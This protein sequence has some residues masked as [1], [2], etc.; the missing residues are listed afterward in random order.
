MVIFGEDMP[1]GK[2]IPEKFLERSGHLCGGFA[3]S[4]EVDVFKV[5]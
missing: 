5:D 2:P 4:N 3:E 1:F